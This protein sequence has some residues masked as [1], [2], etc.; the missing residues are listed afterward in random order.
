MQ[1]DTLTQLVQQALLLTLWLS[2]PLVLAAAA[3]GIVLGILQALTQLQD[4]TTAF[5][6]KVAVVFGLLLVIAPWLGVKLLAFGERCFA[7][8]VGLKV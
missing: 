8:I 7:L 3:V 4:Q 5:A 2:A 1:P 6:I